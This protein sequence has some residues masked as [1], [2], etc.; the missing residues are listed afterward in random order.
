MFTKILKMENKHPSIFDQHRRLYH[1]IKKYLIFEIL[2]ITLS[3]EKCNSV[4][5]LNRSL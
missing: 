1:K 5:I 4:N 2:Y 3:F